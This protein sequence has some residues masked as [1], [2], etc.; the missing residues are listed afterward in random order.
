MTDF[1]NTILI[2][3]NRI[4]SEEVKAGN[5]T[6]PALFTNK[7]GDGVRLNVGDKV[8]VHSGFISE[9]GAGAGVIEFSG[10]PKNYQYTLKQTKTELFQPR[11]SIAS[12]GKT[13]SD[14]D[15]GDMQPYNHHCVLKSQEEKTYTL[16]DNIGHLEINY[17]KT[18][19]GEGYFHLPRRFDY[20]KPVYSTTP[21]DLSLGSTYTGTVGRVRNHNASGGQFN[22]YN[23]NADQN[24]GIG[25]VL[26]SYN[27][28]RVTCNYLHDYNRCLDDVY[29]YMLPG[30]DI[31]SDVPI[32]QTSRLYKNKNDNSRYTLFVKEITYYADYRCIGKWIGNPKYLSYGKP[33][34]EE[35]DYNLEPHPRSNS[36]SSRD[37]L[38]GNGEVNHPRDPALSEYIRYNEI[39]EVT[40]NSG[41]AA[42]ENI[43]ET[44][45]NQLNEVVTDV[46]I[47]GEVGGTFRGPTP[48]NYIGE[49]T[50]N[51]IKDGY[52]VTAG[53]GGTIDSQPSLKSVII[54]RR[55]D[56]E[57]Y[58]T[59]PCANYRSFQ[60][61]GYQQWV[62][63]ASGYTEPGRDY[64]STTG[65]PIPNAHGEQDQVQNYLAS[66]TTIGIKRPDLF[67]AGRIMAKTLSPGK[68]AG[69]AISVVGNSRK[70]DGSVDTNLSWR[71]IWN[72]FIMNDLAKDIVQP[73]QPQQITGANRGTV[74]VLLS[75]EWNETNLSVLTNY[76]TIQGKYP[77]LW[78]GFTGYK[79]SLVE[80]LTPSNSRFIHINSN[81]NTTS[82]GINNAV[83]PLGND[84]YESKDGDGVFVDLS[85][86]PLFFYF[87]ESR[88]D[89]AEGGTNDNNLYNGLFTKRR[90]CFPT[91]VAANQ[92][93]VIAITCR[94][95][96]GIA[97]QHFGETQGLDQPPPVP[98]D[99]AVLEVQGDRTIGYDIHFNAYGTDAICLY[100][101]LL[102]GMPSSASA[103]SQLYYAKDRAPPF[104]SPA[105]D[106]G[107][108]QGYYNISS[109]I[110]EVY[111]GA[112]TPALSFDDT[113]SRFNFETLHTPEVIGNETLA[114]MPAITRADHSNYLSTIAVPALD[115]AKNPVVK[116]NKRLFPHTFCPNMMPYTSN[117][118]A[119][120]YGPYDGQGD[121]DSDPGPPVVPATTKPARG[122]SILSTLNTNMKK[123][124]IYDS[125]CG[126]A[127]QNF[128]ID[129][130]TMWNDSLWGILGFSFNQFRN[131]NTLSNQTRITNS[132]TQDNIGSITTNANI[133]AADT[134][135]FSANI[136]G[137]SLYDGTVG[138]P[139]VPRIQSIR[140]FY[141]NLNQSVY[142]AITID[143]VSAK[144]N[145]ENLPRKMLRPY[146]LIKSNIIGDVNFLGG[147]D[148]GQ[149]MPIMYIVN[150]ENGFGDF[151]FQ[152]QAQTEFTITQN[153]VLTEI[154]TSIHDP[155]FD[156][157]RV[158]ENS[159]IIYKI[160]KNASMDTNVAEEVFKKLKKK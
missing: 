51:I 50:R 41:H 8:S 135:K 11:Y 148:S 158:D 87:D 30:K 47:V 140:S 44:I 125:P 45:T 108:D 141:T 49:T 67:E 68:N 127:I 37:D 159:A 143:Q 85:S 53:G 126:I 81:V 16:Q 122:D 70:P 134:I 55:L 72:P 1:T 94:K 76:F 61:E 95:V 24:D 40:I 64:P 89:K 106:S 2:D 105:T 103:A 48:D 86:L 38:K 137:E 54:G 80:G 101:G 107:A 77:E 138:L 18:T 17:Y 79:G 99:D 155:D 121:P 31:G 7:V 109:Q 90:G 119:S 58:K 21:I 110:K 6:V 59:F 19:N 84:N 123:W 142:P 56:S 157:A 136:N 3:C 57:C 34:E 153:K 120:F 130:Q 42:P 28:G 139:V 144:V 91:D 104:G 4:N 66:Y 149:A 43:A 98:A 75:Y 116:I 118:V 63:D 23:T 133:N 128:G 112:Q 27:T 5:T 146:F 156:H 32:A 100:T 145:A 124:G 92:Y 82:T 33:W 35:P 10:K 88:K 20:A 117:N 83:N 14:T 96:G 22:L 102:D 160:V 115:G 60:K 74:E 25:N 132:V 46:D 151:Y 152:G 150:K 147:E 73:N 113:A 154:T 36:T 131:P 52:G 65:T 13:R 114:G 111:V 129:D 69:E 29:Y 12:N 78:S 97:D 9:R 39:K 26:D 62:G 15:E 93:D 71:N